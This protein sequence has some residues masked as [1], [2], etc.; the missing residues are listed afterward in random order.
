MSGWANGSTEHLA[1][2]LHDI[3]SSIHSL[4]G[5]LIICASKNKENIFEV[6]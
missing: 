5:S 3:C 2:R 6:A 1:K 4:R